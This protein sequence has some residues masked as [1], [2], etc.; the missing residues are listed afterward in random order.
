[1]DASTHHL[2]SRRGAHT[3]LSCCSTRSETHT[4]RMCCAYATYSRALCNMHVLR[5]LGLRLCNMHS[6][7]VPSGTL[8]YHMRVLQLLDPSYRSCK[9]QIPVLIH[10]THHCDD[11]VGQAHHRAQQ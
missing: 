5:L 4:H 3:T 2:Q 7:A 9:L 8:A 1:V 10:A 6:S 11:A